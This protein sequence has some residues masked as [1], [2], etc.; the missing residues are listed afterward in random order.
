VEGRRS[1]G[2]PRVRPTEIAIIASALLFLV[3][4]ALPGSNEERV[5]VLVTFALI[6]GYT[7]V[8]YHVLPQ[9]TFG[10]SRYAV[11]GTIVQLVLVYMLLATG[12][13]RSAWFVFYLL[14]LLSTVFSYRSGSTA[15]VAVV[16]ALGLVVVALADPAVR[17]VEDARDQLAVRVVGLGAV[18][19]MAYVITRV[20]RSHRDG[21]EQKEMR[22][23]EVL[24]STE[25]DA[26]TDALTAVHNRRA[27]ERSLARA[28]SR[29]ARDGH[30]YSVLLIDVDGLKRLN[31]RQGHAAGDRALRTIATAATD[32]VRGYDVVARYGGDEFVVVLHES[33]EGAAQ[34]TAERIRSRV[35]QLLGADGALTGTTISIG[36][37]TWRTG[38]TPEELLAEADAAMYAAKP[39]RR[40]AAS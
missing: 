21:L 24:A 11:G 34:A 36:S 1:G 33:A 2:L 40:G 26:M 37:A 6:I 23:R 4:A 10:G 13:V 15:T 22:L 3:T 5:G 29:A 30:A 31:D 12:G 38:R 39:R 14:P 16:A 9:G 18:A 20:M 7:A 35:H 32:S 28:N 25:R 17:T 27:L 19:M 8:W